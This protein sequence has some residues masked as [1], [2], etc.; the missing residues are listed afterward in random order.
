M[1]NRLK[2]FLI[3]VAVGLVNACGAYEEKELVVQQPFQ[4]GSIHRSHGLSSIHLAMAPNHV[5]A[6]AVDTS[7][8]GPLHPGITSDEA[9]KILGLPSRVEKDAFGE[10][11][12]IWSLPGMTARVGCQ[13]G[14]SGKTPT[15]CR[16]MLSGTVRDA[17]NMLTAPAKRTVNQARETLPSQDVEVVITSGPESID[18]RLKPNA[19]ITWLDASRESRRIG[20]PP[21]GKCP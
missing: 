21:V 2:G 20:A 3:V 13:F 1:S 7:L 5:L 6:E 16:W 17:S 14:C 12:R 10:E 15:F 4:N 9:V 18:F 19:T 11:W 8:F